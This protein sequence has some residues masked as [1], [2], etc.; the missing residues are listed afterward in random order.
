MTGAGGGSEDLAEDLEVMDAP[1][2]L[3]E[4][5]RAEKETEVLDI[6]RE[7]WPAVRLFAACGTQWRL[8]GMSGLPT[9]LDYAGVEAA[10]RMAGIEMSEDLF[11]RLRVMERAALAEMTSRHK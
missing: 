9:G 10:A 6:L 11:G 2:E 4:Q 1:A 5:A 7:N 8:A 3:V